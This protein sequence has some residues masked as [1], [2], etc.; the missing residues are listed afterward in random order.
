[1]V[2]KEVYWS[3]KDRYTLS[4]TPL[5]NI[6]VVL[7]HTKIPPSPKSHIQGAFLLKSQ[8]F[9]ARLK[10]EERISVLFKIIVAIAVIFPI[11]IVGGLLY[12]SIKSQ[13]F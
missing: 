5:T 1:M 2:S 3:L 11:K 9:I 7:L 4:N 12:K 10:V 13:N 6:N 8:R